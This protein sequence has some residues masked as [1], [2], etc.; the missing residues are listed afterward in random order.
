[1]KVI[2]DCEILSLSVP[3]LEKM[4]HEFP[5][6]YEELWYDGQIKL[7]DHLKAKKKGIKKCFMKR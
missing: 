3:D 6:I 4:R 5:Q 7:K 1:M 2:K